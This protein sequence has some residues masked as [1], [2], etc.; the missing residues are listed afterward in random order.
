MSLEGALTSSFPL[1][2]S[3]P[4]LQRPEIPVLPYACWSGVCFVDGPADHLLVVSGA[5]GWTV[6]YHWLDAG[7]IGL[8]MGLVCSRDV[9]GLGSSVLCTNYLVRLPQDIDLPWAASSCN[10]CQDHQTFT[11]RVCS[12]KLDLSCLCA[13]LLLAL[14]F[15][16]SPARDASPPPRKVSR[17]PSR[18]RSRSRS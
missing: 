13:C 4:P 15:R 5:L 18:S 12:C 11:M 3:Q 1:A 14:L 9:F 16:R 17:S 7:R 2:G 8:D 6:S 10:A